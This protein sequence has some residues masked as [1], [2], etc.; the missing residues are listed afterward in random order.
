MSFNPKVTSNTL[1]EARGIAKNY[2]G[3][4]ALEPMDLELHAGELTVLLGS[5]GAGKSTLLRLISG[6][7]APS[8]GSLHLYG[9]IGYISGD[10]KLY[11]RLTPR[12]TL[13]FFGRLQG[14]QANVLTKRISL[15]TEKMQLGPF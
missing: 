1:F 15:M 12:E 9:S 5:N 3:C 6:L 10:T 7:L 14:L 11:D 4:C 13:D 2:G 8:Q